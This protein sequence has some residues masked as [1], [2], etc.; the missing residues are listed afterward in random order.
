MVQKRELPVRSTKY[1][2]SLTE[3]QNT[4]RLGNLLSTR[5]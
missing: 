4:V 2:L 3:A 5:P 1:S